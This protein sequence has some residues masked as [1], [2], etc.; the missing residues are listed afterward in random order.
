MNAR[1]LHTFNIQV[2]YQ[3]GQMKRSP[4]LVVLLNKWKR[5]IRLCNV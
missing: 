5:G 2:V 4:P 1:L 3:C